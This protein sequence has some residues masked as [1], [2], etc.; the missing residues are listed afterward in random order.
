MTDGTSTTGR[1]SYTH[2]AYFFIRTGVRK[3]RVFGYWKDGGRFKPKPDADGNF[4]AMIDMLP[5]GGWDGRVEFVKF[6][7]PPPP[8]E[9]QAPQRPDG[10]D[11]GSDGEN[12]ES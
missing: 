10:N 7:D 12:F 4:V 3:G 5:R 11:E 9:P 6:G 8:N 2:T 1:P